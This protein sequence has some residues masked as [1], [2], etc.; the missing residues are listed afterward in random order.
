MLRQ[1][2]VKHYSGLSSERPESLPFGDFYFEEDTG[3]LY[4]YGQDERAKQTS[5]LSEESLEEIPNEIQGHYGILTGYYFQGGD[6]TETIIAEDD[7]DDWVDVNFTISPDGIY[8]KRPQVMK[9]ANG[10][11]ALEGSGTQADPYVFKL[12]GLT[13]HGRGFFRASL[14]F[15][16]DEDEGQLESRLDFERHSGTVPNE[17]FPIE[18]VTL[19]MSQGVDKDYSAEPFLSFFVGDTIDTNGV[20]DAGKCKFQVKSSVPG[21]LKMRALTWFINV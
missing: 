5:K 18:E 15:E 6:S 1:Y 10:G 4:K 14:A 2:T 21:T 9:D 11:V 12:E 13:T 16:P 19:T 8:D 7:T 17:N 20:G 3:Q